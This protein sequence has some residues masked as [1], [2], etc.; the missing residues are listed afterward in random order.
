MKL[1]I[2]MVQDCHTDT[3]PW[4]FDT[5]KAAIAAARQL[6]RG[7]ARRT[8]DYVEA[9]IAGWLF[10]ARYSFEGDAVWVVAKELNAPPS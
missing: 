5:A 9:P 10:H 4:A 8:E 2:L 3:E 6:A 7:L 1:Y